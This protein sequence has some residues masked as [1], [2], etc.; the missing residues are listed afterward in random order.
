MDQQK[1]SRKKYLWW[2]LLIALL[3]VLGIGWMHWGPCPCC[4]R[5]A[6]DE[7]TSRR[8]EETDGG[9]FEY[10]A[11]YHATGGTWTLHDK[12]I[13]VLKEMK[14]VSASELDRYVVRTLTPADRVRI[15]ESRQRWK[16]VEVLDAGKVVATGW[17]DANNVRKPVRAKMD[18]P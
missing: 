4:R 18:A 3:I 16:K 1:K 2:L 17:I 13:H 15:V 11:F 9:R 14:Y 10:S 6:D 8:A 7:A 5:Q 12:D